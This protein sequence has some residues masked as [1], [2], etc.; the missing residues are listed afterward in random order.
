VRAKGWFGY[1]LEYDRRPGDPNAC[2]LWYPIDKVKG[3]GIEE[4]AGYADRM[5]LYYTTDMRRKYNCSTDR[6]VPVKIGSEYNTDSCC[7]NADNSC[8]DDS[9]GVYLTSGNSYVALQ[10]D[11]LSPYGFSASCSGDSRCFTT[12]ITYTGSGITAIS[13]PVYSDGTYDYYCPDSGIV[14]EVIATF[15]RCGAVKNIPPAARVKIKQ[16]YAHEIVQ[17]VA[18]MGNNKYW[19]S[20]VYKGSDYNYSCNIDM[21]DYALTLLA[22]SSPD[23]AAD[24]A[25]AKNCSY[26][27]DYAPFGSII[28]PEPVSNPYEWDSD[29]EK[30]GVQPLYYELDKNV[31]RAGREQTVNDV[32]RLFAKSYGAWRWD[33]TASRYL[34]D[35]T[36]WG[37][38]G[39]NNE[40]NNGLCNTS[41]VAPRPTNFPADYCAILP[42]ISNIKV[43]GSV[44]SV[45]LANSQFVKLSFNSKVDSQQLPLVMYGVDWGDNSKTVVTGVEMRDKPDPEPANPS[46]DGAP[47]AIY[48]LY[49][50]WDMKAKQA[51][52]PAASDTIYCGPAGGSALNR[53]G[54]NSGLACPNSPNNSACCMAKPKV[55]IKDN[56]GWCNHGTAINACG[57]NQWDTFAGWVVVKEK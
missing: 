38:P 54:L 51:T 22:P 56:W 24:I 12:L 11:V 18:P 45:T 52:N 29:I 9:N 30:T 7:Q 44:D 1:C 35:N 46:N 39:A 10:Y 48:H 25:S 32:K 55:Q 36:N 8:S 47:E 17:V 23:Y 16:F 28:N 2:L 31:V 13:P 41:G 26:N 43:N 5:P 20:R 4:G 3:D 57:A 37:P 27:S 6:L 14:P 19:S 21:P 53:A 49:S 15:G 40:P 34:I 33:T 50:Y 42:A